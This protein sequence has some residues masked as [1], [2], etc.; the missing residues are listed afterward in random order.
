MLIDG[1]IGDT[2]GV[3]AAAA[4][5]EPQTAIRDGVVLV[6]RLSRVSAPHTPAAPPWTGTVLLTGANGPDAATI[7]RHLV[8]A[9][10]VTDLVLVS[11]EGPADPAAA[12]LRAE[13]AE[14]GATVTLLP[15]DLTRPG[16]LDD[17]AVRVSAVVHNPAAPD[18]VAA[19]VA[20]LTAVRAAV[21]DAPLVAVVSTAGR[22]GADDPREAAVGAYTEAFLRRAGASGVAIGLRPGDGLSDQ[23]LMGLF[24][25]AVAT[26]ES[27]LFVLDPDVP[28]DVDGPL[29]TPLRGIVEAPPAP[30]R[31]PTTPSRPAGA[32]G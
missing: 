14:L 8:T 22:L 18:D 31:R 7:G 13:L 19:E 24:D 12:D 11:P 21:P 27:G 20:A 15:V 5:G 29:T 26:G 6:P 25:A 10:K 9:H 30:P 23:E 17:L 16:A 2:D 1:D 4:T 28:A 3:A 32:T